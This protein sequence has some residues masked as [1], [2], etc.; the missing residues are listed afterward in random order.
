MMERGS[1]TAA[2]VPPKTPMA[3]GFLPA[4]LSIDRGS[5]TKNAQ[6]GITPSCA[7]FF[8]F[9]AFLSLRIILRQK[10]VEDHTGDGRQTDTGQLETADADLHP[11]HAKNDDQGHDDHIA[12]PQHIL[13]GTHQR[14]QAHPMMAPNSK[15]MIPPMT[16]AGMQ[17]RNAPTLA[18][19]ES[20]MAHRAAQV[21]PAGLK[22]RVRVTA[23]VTSE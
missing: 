22:A 19:M 10:Q 15:I 21:M 11:A 8:S 7:S 5:R 14:V 3:E 6:D 2:K 23:P 12:G 16:G 18:T 1:P 4:P 9:R 17:L 13:P 20:R